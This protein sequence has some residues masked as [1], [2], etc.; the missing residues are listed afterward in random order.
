VLEAYAAGVPVV[1]SY[2]GGIP[3]PSWEGETGF[4][5]SPTQA[6]AWTE[7]ANRLPDYSETSRLDEGAIGCG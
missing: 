2:I 7:A 1:G 3:D 4:L 5:V 6:G